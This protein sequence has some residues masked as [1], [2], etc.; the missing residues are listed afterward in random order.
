MIRVQVA[1][2][3]RFDRPD[4]LKLMAATTEKSQN[5]FAFMT[6]RRGSWQYDLICAAIL[7]FI[8]LTPARFFGV[9]PRP[10]SVRQ[11]QQLDDG[12]TTVYWVDA[13]AVAGLDDATREKRLLELAREL[14]GPE[15]SLVSAAAAPGPNG[16]SPGYL[17]YARR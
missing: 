15:L 8:F 2:R 4:T 14:D 11:V 16:D 1:V 3:L 17:V 7:A 12:A 5:S 10:E 13:E 6:F 9:E